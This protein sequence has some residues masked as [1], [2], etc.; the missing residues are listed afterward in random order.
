[1]AIPEIVR[2]GLAASNGNI[3]FDHSWLFRVFNCDRQTLFA[4]DAANRLI[5]KSMTF[6]VNS[7]SPTYF[8]LTG[9][10]LISIWLCHHQESATLHLC[11][12]TY[13]VL[14]ALTDTDRSANDTMSPRRSLS[15]SSRVSAQVPLSSAV[16]SGQPGVFARTTQSHYQQSQLGSGNSQSALKTVPPTPPGHPRRSYVGHP[17]AYHPP[18]L[19]T[20]PVVRGSVWL[21][22]FYL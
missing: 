9:F 18:A 6:L 22:I 5:S 8:L 16:S 4:H 20:T 12:I 17:A 15:V 10:P 21:V 14:S 11:A 1:M 19:A 2:A 13:C 7:N 3:C